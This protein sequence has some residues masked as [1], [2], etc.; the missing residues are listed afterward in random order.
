MKKGKNFQ[1]GKII[2]YMVFTKKCGCRCRCKEPKMWRAQMLLKVLSM[3]QTVAVHPLEYSR[4]GFRNAGKVLN[5][6]ERF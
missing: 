1:F 5:L 6:L 2:P 3:E 4:K